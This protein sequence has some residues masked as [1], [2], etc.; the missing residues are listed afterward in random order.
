M[1]IKNAKDQVEIDHKGFV[2]FETLGGDQ[3][4]YL[5]W[6]E[7]TPEEEQQVLQIR[8]EGKELLKRSMD[9]YAAILKRKDSS[10]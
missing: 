3:S 9:L 4:A 10:N 8:A 5:D 7:L 6:P 2:F 1:I